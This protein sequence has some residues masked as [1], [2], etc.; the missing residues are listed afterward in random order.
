MIDSA[1][2]TEPN[3]RLDNLAAARIDFVNRN[4]LVTNV[5]LDEIYL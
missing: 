2:S 3:E 4:M 5:K 1:T